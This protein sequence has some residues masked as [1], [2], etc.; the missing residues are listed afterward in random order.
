MFSF[1]C[2][3]KSDFGGVQQEIAERNGRLY[4]YGA[5]QV[6][7]NNVSVANGCFGVALLCALMHLRDPEKFEL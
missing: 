4:V 6:V 3:G 2:K 1:L 7:C 5:F